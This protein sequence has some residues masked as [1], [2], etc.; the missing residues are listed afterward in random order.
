MTQLRSAKKR[1]FRFGYVGVALLL[2]A[3]AWWTLARPSSQVIEERYSRGLYPSIASVLVPITNS[4]PFSISALLLVVIP[5]LWLVWTISSLRKRH[6]LKWLWRTLL[7]AAILYA[8]F[9]L[10]WGANYQRESTETQLGLATESFTETELQTLVNTLSSVIQENVNAERN[11]AKAR[12]SLRASLIGTVETITGVQPT[13]PPWVKSLP[14]GTLILLGNASGVISPFTLEPHVDGALPDVYSLAVGAHELAHIAGYAGEADADF[15]SALAGLNA[16]DAFA[17]YAVALRLWS[18]AV[19]QLPSE[20]RSQAMRDL[21]Q[22][23]RDDLEAS[24]EPFRRY[25][26]PSWLQAVQSS[27][28]DRYLTSQ[29]VEAGIKDYSRIVTLLLAAQRKGL[30]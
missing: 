7:S 28:Y 10:N 3:L 1:R 19:A 9:V 20:Q 5:I 12:A 13:L 2:A 30:L 25:R 22:L 23:A 21:P 16:D 15:I 17:K 4:V 29:G 27:L 26:L 14:A 24:Y 11:V 18:D 8:L 6:F